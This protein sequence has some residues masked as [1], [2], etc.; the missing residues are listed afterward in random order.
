M[1]PTDYQ[2]SF[3]RSFLSLRRDHVHTTTTT[4]TDVLART[5]S[6]DL[7][8][9]AFQKC[10]AD[11]F[12]DLSSSSSTDDLLS[13]SW[14]RKLLDVFLIC[15]EDFRI[16]VLSDRLNADIP[17]SSNRLV[18]DFFDRCVKALDVC[19]AIRDGIDQI[20]QWTILI[21]IVLVALRPSSSHFALGE[22]HLRR[23][24]KALADLAISMLD[25]KD[26]VGGV[27][28]H[29]NRSFGRH[30]NNNNI[31]RSSS[32]ATRH[33]RSLSWS[34]SRT[35][36]AA[37]QIQ[38][39]GNN[40]VPPKTSEI[41]ATNGLALPIYTM[42]SVLLVVMWVL[43]AA[44]P[45]Q[46]RGVQHHFSFPRNLP[47]AAPV[48]SICDRIMEESK[49][50]DRRNSNG[51]LMEFEKIERCARALSELTE[52]NKVED[53]KMDEVKENVQE[54]DEICRAIREG[55]DPLEKQ[56]REVFRQIVRSRTES[57]DRL[58]LHSPSSSSSS[59]SAG[60][61]H[62]PPPHHQK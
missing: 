54:L 35:W 13:I 12:I 39:I 3:G 21:D 40:L 61:A 18:L 57:L 55:L 5:S 14:I 6:Q 48:M 60:T 58:L 50:K 4:T 44:V 8:L 47:W 56:V 34:V 7:E 32:P 59:S 16:L 45:C 1:P 11:L 27:F 31:H 37:K 42:N 38:A 24:N 10:V 23:A 33:F 51:L 46:D 41:A 52:L 9:Q 49:K 15:K 62:H 30:G 2:G 43:V 53:D 36:S 19:N 26:S 22:G 25:D 17:A 20:R 28:S 29:R